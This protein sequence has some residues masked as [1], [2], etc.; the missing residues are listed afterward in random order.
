MFRH[1]RRAARRFRRL[2]RPAVVLALVLAQC[3]AAFGFPVV[4]RGGEVVRRCGCKVRGPLAACCCG[5]RECCGGVAGQPIPEPEV[6]ACP[7]CK[8]KQSANPS[9]PTAKKESATV[10]WVAGVKARQCHGDSGPT[11]LIIESPAIPPDTPSWPP[12]GPIPLGV[13]PVGDDHLTSHVFVP[14]D[15]PPRRG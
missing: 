10:T 5:P 3:V 9:A 6:P 1:P 2:A 12:A 11:G 8:V 7:K 4:V 14:P 15:P 13:V